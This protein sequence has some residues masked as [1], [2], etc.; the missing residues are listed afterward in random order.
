MSIPHVTLP[1]YAYARNALKKQYG[2]YAEPLYAT[3]CQ[4]A[5]LIM[6]GQAQASIAP[7]HREHFDEKLDINHIGQFF[8]VYISNS[9]NAVVDHVYSAGVAN[10]AYDTA[11]AVDM[12]HSSQVD[13][14][15]AQFLDRCICT[16][17]TY[18]NSDGEHVRQQAF[19]DF[20]AVL[21]F[22]E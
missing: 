1:A 8:T 13:I 9:Y 15:A 14:A 7:E 11:G 17:V 4:W 22:V 6:S 2:E 19:F 21:D 16:E 20:N 12:R 5:A 10:G 3:W 18:V